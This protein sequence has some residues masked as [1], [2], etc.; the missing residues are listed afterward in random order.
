[1]RWSEPP[2]KVLKMSRMPPACANRAFEDQRIDARQRHEAEEAEHDQRT[3]REPDA[4][5]QFGRLRKVG[6]LSV[7]AMLSARDAMSGQALDGAAHI[8]VA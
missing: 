5:L 4:V 8:R 2:E 3:N 6:R 1:M 7:L